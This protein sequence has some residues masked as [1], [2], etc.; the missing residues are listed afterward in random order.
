MLPSSKLFRLPGHASFSLK[1][2]Y[3]KEQ[4]IIPL[5]QIRR[6]REQL[7]KHAFYSKA[8]KKGQNRYSIQIH[9]LAFSKKYFFGISVFRHSL[10]K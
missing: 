3:N 8:K 10:K 1:S 6:Q 9:S 4:Y 7:K 5:T 2:Q